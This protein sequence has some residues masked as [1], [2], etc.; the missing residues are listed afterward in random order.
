MACLRHAL[1]IRCKCYFQTIAL[2]KKKKPNQRLDSELVK[3]KTALKRC[4]HCERER[5]R[6]LTCFTLKAF[7]SSGTSVKLSSSDKSERSE[8]PSTPSKPAYDDP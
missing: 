3:M 5:E 7:V 8:A 1:A 2:Q 6:E 4:C